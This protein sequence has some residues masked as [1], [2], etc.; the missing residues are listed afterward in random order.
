LV[1]GDRAAEAEAIFSRLLADHGNTAELSVVL[2][3]AYAQQ[4]NFDAAVEA[5]Q[6][7]P[8]VADANNALGLIYLKQGKLP[9]AETAL[10]G[11]VAAHPG[12]VKARERLATVLDLLG[13]SDQAAGELRTVLAAKPDFANAQYL[14]GKILLGRGDTE[15]AIGHLEVAARLAPDEANTRYQLARAYQKAGRTEQAEKEFEAYQRLKDTQ[16]GKTP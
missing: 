15:Q 14:L 2:G 12:N 3:H 4:G 7:N 1:R 8:D 16:R 10:R 9:E 5:L 13:H 11:E 6:L